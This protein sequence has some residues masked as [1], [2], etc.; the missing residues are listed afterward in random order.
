M[1]ELKEQA[2]LESIGKLTVSYENQ[3]ANLRVELTNKHSEYTSLQEQSQT[4]VCNPPA[5]AGPVYQE[6]VVIN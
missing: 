6:G 5:E 4:H 1:S 2:L 3:L